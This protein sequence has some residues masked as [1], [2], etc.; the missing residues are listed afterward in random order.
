M[1]L[2]IENSGIGVTVIIILTSAVNLFLH[3][4]LLLQVIKKI[5]SCK[6]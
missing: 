4:L 1:D 5:S 6:W 3:L 2:K